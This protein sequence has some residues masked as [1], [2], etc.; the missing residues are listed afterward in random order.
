[1]TEDALKDAKP[2]DLFIY[3]VDDS[4]AFNQNLFSNVLHILKSGYEN[5]DNNWLTDVCRVGKIQGNRPI[6]LSFASSQIKQLVF[7]ALIRQTNK[8]KVL[9]SNHLS[10]AEQSLEP[11]LRDIARKL[12]ANRIEEKA[13][14]GNLVVRSRRYNLVKAQRKYHRILGAQKT[15]WR[16]RTMRFLVTS[17]PLPNTGRQRKRKPYWMTN[18]L[19]RRR[20]LKLQIMRELKCCKKGTDYHHYQKMKKTDGPTSKL[21]NSTF[22]DWIVHLQK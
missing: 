1:M 16:K 17:D 13:K 19:V 14:K 21:R 4:K 20:Q 2:N 6:M 15:W 3:H 12:K 22:G 7:K 9:P 11:N 8:L 10:S 18:R 5:F